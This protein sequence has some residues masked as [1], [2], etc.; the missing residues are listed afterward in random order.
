MKKALISFLL[1]LAIVFS[2]A[3]G[4]GAEEQH[5]IAVVVKVAG[6][7][8]FSR[9]EE[10]VKQAAKDFGVNAYMVGP[11]T[12]DPAPQVQMVEDLVTRGV[13]AICV[14]PSDA[15]SLAPVFNRAREQGIVILT[16]ESPF[17]TEA[18]DWD[19]ETIDSVQYGK[20]PVDAIVEKL[21]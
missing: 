13:D 19:V 5:E 11:T 1:V 9:L 10:G 16:H 3:L 4:V 20:A 18:V 6:I 8:W 21:K 14:V 2:F 12:A 7:P 15:K 17:E